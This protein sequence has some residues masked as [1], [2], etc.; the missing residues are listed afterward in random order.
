VRRARIVGFRH[1]VVGPNFLGSRPHRIRNNL[2]KRGLGPTALDK[3]QPNDVWSG[4]FIFAGLRSL[5]V[6]GFAFT[7]GGTTIE[8][9]ENRRGSRTA[10]AKP[11]RQHWNLRKRGGGAARPVPRNTRASKMRPEALKN[12]AAHFD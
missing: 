6:A 11:G 9:P 8:N 5:V 7:G 10:V 3:V 1:F 12:V 2:E 4:D